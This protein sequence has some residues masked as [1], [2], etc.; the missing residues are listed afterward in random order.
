MLPAQ[1]TE[2]AGMVILNRYQAE[3]G[4]SK[5]FRRPFRSG[6]TWAPGGHTV[7]RRSDRAFEVP[8]HPGCTPKEVF[9]TAPGCLNCPP[10]LDVYLASQHDVPGEQQPH[11]FLLLSSDRPRR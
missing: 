10:Q 3:A 6:E 4:T 8:S 11:L 2:V 5:Q 7:G 1:A 9:K